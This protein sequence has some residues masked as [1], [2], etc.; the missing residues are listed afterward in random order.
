MKKLL[1]ILSS[2]LLSAICATAQQNSIST[3]ANR[4]AA[5]SPEISGSEVTFRL[6]ADYATVVRL[7]AGWLSEPVPM[8]KS[9]GVW[10]VTVDLPQPEIHT[11]HFIVDGVSVLDPSNSAMR[12]DGTRYSN[13]L[14][15][16]GPAS[17]NYFDAARRG[18]V[19][20]I[21]YDSKVLGISRRLAV[22]LPDGYFDKANAKTKYP[23]LYL[24]HGDG[25]DEE[26]WVS[27]GRASRI[28][29]NLIAQGKASRMIVVMLNCNPGQQAAA[30]LGLPEFDAAKKFASPVHAMSRS[31]CEEIVPFVESR[32]RAQSKQSFRILSGQP[33]D[34]GIALEVRMKYP[35]VFGKIMDMPLSEGTDQWSG[36]RVQL[37]ELVP[38]MFK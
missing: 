30:D 29:D 21:W 36:N 5:V 15:V 10:S 32:F 12:R 8:R 16:K 18:A 24:L 34:S 27:K 38:K 35:N 26:S 17:A 7:S 37:N 13:L 20:Y 31:L 25:E 33:S 2:I 22:Y 28:L 23:V 6:A 3:S 11:Y 1:V 14:M 4:P 19:E 9:D